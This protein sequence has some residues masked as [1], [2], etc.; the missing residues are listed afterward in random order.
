MVKVHPFLLSSV[1]TLQ[2]EHLFFGC[3]SFFFYNVI[4]ALKMPHA[5]MSWVVSYKMAELINKRNR[6][7]S[8]NETYLKCAFRGADLAAVWRQYAL[9]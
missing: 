3:D 8:R 6:Q 7:S 5:Q 9:K 2:F 4:S 1:T